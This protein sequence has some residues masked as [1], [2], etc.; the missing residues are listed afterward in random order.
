MKKHN[1]CEGCYFLKSRSNMRTREECSY[2]ITT[3]SSRV[4]KEKELAKMTNQEVSEK[5]CLCHT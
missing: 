5:K 2:C 1:V 4:L 3:G